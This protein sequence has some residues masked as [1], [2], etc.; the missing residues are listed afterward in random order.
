MTAT[1]AGLV[2]LAV[3]LVALA[4]AWRPLVPSLTGWRSGIG[5]VSGPGGS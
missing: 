4:V 2:Q 3:L 1:A 5:A